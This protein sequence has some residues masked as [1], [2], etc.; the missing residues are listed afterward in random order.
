MGKHTKFITGLKALGAIMV[1]ISHLKMQFSGYSDFSWKFITFSSYFIML[2]ICIS[3]FTIAMSLDRRNEFHFLSYIKRRYL[4]LAPSYYVAII[5]GFFM[6]IAINGWQYYYA[7]L[8]NLPYVF[9]FLNLDPIHIPS[10]ASILNVEWMLPILFWFY[11]LI[12]LLL[13]LVRKIPSLFLLVFATSI[14]LHFNPTAIATYTGFGGFGWSMQF[15][16][17]PYVYTMLVYYLFTSKNFIRVLPGIGVLLCFSLLFYFIDSKSERI[18]AFFLLAMTVYLLWIKEKIINIFQK[19]STV[20]ASILNNL[21]I[22]VLIVILVKYM[23]NLYFIKYPHLILT[24]W[25]IALLIACFHRPFITRFLFENKY[26]Q[27]LGTISFGIYLIHPL[28]I[29]LTERFAPM[30]YPYFRV[31]LIF[32]LTILAAY[33]LYKMIE[34]RLNNMKA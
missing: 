22:P 31:L 1:V 17:L 5:I 19:R 9:L 11:F 6:R 7:T 12:P 4:R 32:P 24:F 2:F 29:L 14:Y 20:F 28:I 10:Q 13:Y 3:A 23:I 33:M 21:D 25:F 34:V 27:F 16:I 15:Y 8:G 18:Y 26:M 30:E